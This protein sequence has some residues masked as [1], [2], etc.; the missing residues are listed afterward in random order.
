[1]SRVLGCRKEKIGS[2]VLENGGRRKAKETQEEVIL[3]DV[4]VFLLFEFSACWGLLLFGQPDLNMAEI[5]GCERD[6]H[7]TL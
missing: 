4:Q 6:N 7:S 3:L 5:G 1:M 2:K